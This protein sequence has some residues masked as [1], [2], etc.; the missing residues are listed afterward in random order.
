ML[1]LAKIGLETKIPPVFEQHRAYARELI[2][3]IA[4]IYGERSKT[5]YFETSLDRYEQYLAIAQELDSD[6]RVLEVGSAPGHVSVGL[7]LLGFQLSCLNLNELYR[8]YYPSAEWIERLR[9]VEHDFEKAPLPYEDESFDAVFFTEVLEHIAIK[10]VIEVLRDIRRVCRPGGTLVLSTP[11]VNNVSNIAALLNGA[12][13][14][15]APE[16]FYGSLDR[17][18]REFTPGEVCEAI[19]AAGFTIRWSYG[20]NCQSNW[21]TE[22]ADFAYRVIGEVGDNHPLLRNT[23]MIVARA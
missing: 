18:N 21:R 2:K 10:P 8:A 22:G 5:P 11:N 16:M 7:F 1:G 17:H 3:R 14:F 12:N 20:F 6:A 15:W 23:V 13:I 9:V 4:E 19:S